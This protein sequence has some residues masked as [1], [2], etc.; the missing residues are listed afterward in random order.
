MHTVPRLF[1]CLVVL[2]VVSLANAGGQQPAGTSLAI[3]SVTII[4][5]SAATAEAAI[6]TDRTVIIRAGRISDVGNSSTTAV[7]ADAQRIDGRGKYLI[8]GLWDMHVHVLSPRREAFLPLLIANGVTGVRDMATAFGPDEIARVRQRIADGSLVGPRMFV[9]GP[10][11]SGGSVGRSAPG[12]I[13]HGWTVTTSDE[14]RGAV[15]TLIGER[16]DF[17][18]VYS[19]LKRDVFEAIAENARANKID[20]A[21]HVPIPVPI[22]DAVR[23][24][25]R[26]IE[27]GT[28]LTLACSSKESELRN[29]AVSVMATG[30]VLRARRVADGD[31]HDTIDD[32]KCAAVLDRLGREEVWHT[33][34]VVFFDAMSK[35]ARGDPPD[36]AMRYVPP[37]A[38]KARDGIAWADQMKP[39][40]GPRSVDAGA[41]NLAMLRRLHRAH[42]RVLA[43]T[44]LGNPFLIPGV[45][46]HDELEHL[47]AAGFSP[48]QAL[49]SATL[50]PA[51]FLRREADIGTIEPGRIADLVLLDAN[52]LEEIRRARQIRAVVAGGRLFDRAALDGILAALEKTP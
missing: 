10:L 44:D 27:H 24:G 39:L 17:L 23:A 21:G 49:Q 42:A 4:D 8:P 7:P 28:G 43:G 45:S 32:A 34:T 29:E 41:R 3:T 20:I 36:P 16:V 31:S 37:S 52:P 15:A 48:L 11:L 46:L 40:I 51:R 35:F 47:V 22:V 2:V 13:A 18:K 14:A 30:D 5:V 38:R 25:L 26:S 19:Y 6:Q 33:P 1:A 12:R 50:E 9:A